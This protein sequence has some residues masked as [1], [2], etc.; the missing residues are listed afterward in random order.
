GFN[1]GGTGARPGKD[2]LS[3]TSFP[4]GIRNVAVEIMETLSPVVYWKK[5]YR[6]DSGGAGE[7]RGGL[8]QIME[9][10]NGEDAPMIISAT[11]DRIVHAAR[12]SAGGKSGGAGRLSLKSGAT[13]RG[14]GRQ[15][16]PAGD[17]VVVE[18]PGGGG[19]GDP[20]KRTHEKVAC[21][22]DYGLVSAEEAQKAY[23]YTATNGTD[24]Q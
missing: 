14:F 9:I 21:D 2:G 22:V 17:R 20:K 6:P 8:G 19:I 15:V 4:S 3:V 1:T 7:H 18:T 5:E 24:R 13:M 10:A 16:I 23:G 12:G 11:F